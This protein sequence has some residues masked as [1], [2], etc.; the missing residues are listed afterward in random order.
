MQAPSSKS[1]ALTPKTKTFVD[2]L[3]AENA[4]PIYTLSPEKAR[5]V[6]IDAQSSLKVKP[7]ADIQDKAVPAG[8]MG[9]VEIRIVR[10]QESKGKL[11]LIFYIHGG[12]WI[13]GDKDTH[14][15]LIRELAVKT[16]FAVL[17]PSFTPA[18]EARFPTQLEQ[19]YALLLEVLDHPIEYGID[20]DNVALVG[21]SVGGNMATALCLMLKQRGNAEVLKKIKIQCLFYPVTNASFDTGSYEAFADGPWLT[22]KSMQWFWDAYA[23]EESRRS[24]IIASPLRASLD[25]LQGLPPACIAT[26]ENDVLRD[27]GEAYAH[28]LMEA[29]VPTTAMRFL[30][31]VHDFVMLDALAETTPTRGAIDFAVSMLRKALG[32]G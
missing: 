9:N 1:P 30:G 22:R 14:D 31:T 18:P 7:A 17:F 27:E 6:L 15:R 13:L 12:G 29:G 28:R 21:D 25:D 2:A 16:G 20:A 24:E 5:R 32:D 4:P 19:L 11:P 26:A 3:A 8:P 23:P 10:P